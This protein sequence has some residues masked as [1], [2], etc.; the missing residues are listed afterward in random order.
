MKRADDNPKSA[1]RRLKK[2]R[3]K[4]LWRA[5][6]YGALVVGAFGF[7]LG[8]GLC[9]WY[10]L[11]IPPLAITEVFALLGAGM[12][13]AWATLVRT[14]VGRQVLN[15]S[16]VGLAAAVPLGLIAPGWAKLGAILGSLSLGIYLGYQK[17]V[18]PEDPQPQWRILR[19]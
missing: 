5:A 15:G 2:Q 16:A 1:E 18:T 4:A 10:R 19:P 17:S 13:A 11:P 8:I 14:P 9:I 12:G 6:G 7:F 3:K